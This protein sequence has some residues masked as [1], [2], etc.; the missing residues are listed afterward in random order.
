[1]TFA[2]G[3]LQTGVS[4]WLVRQGVASG[5]PVP[6]R[7]AFA[8][9]KRSTTIFFYNGTAI[10]MLAASSYIRSLMARSPKSAR[11]GSPSV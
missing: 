9:I 10:L 11:S 6:L 7:A 2:S 1:L 5:W 8:L 3:L 4:Y